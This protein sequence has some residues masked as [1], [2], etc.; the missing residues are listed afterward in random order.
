MSN[1]VSSPVDDSDSRSYSRVPC[2]T[3]ALYRHMSHPEEPQLCPGGAGAEDKNLRERLASGVTGMPEGLT[4]FLINLDIK[5]DR[6]I[7][8]LT[9]DSITEYFSKQFVVLDLSA[10]GLLVQSNELQAGEFLEVALFLGELPSVL[11]SGVT[12]VLRPG[13]PLPGVGSTFA[14]KFVRIRESDREQIVRFVFK[15]DRQRI[16]SA[17]YK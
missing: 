14:L 4:A 6:L 15:E 13:R 11:I 17:K 5:L 9:R 16:R 2:F 12:Q 1:T 8:Y 3:R 10:S 7:D